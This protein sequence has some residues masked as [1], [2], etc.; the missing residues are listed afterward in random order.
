MLYLKEKYHFLQA[1]EM[2]VI[3]KSE[4]LKIFKGDGI[5][6]FDPDN[7]PLD[8]FK[9]ELKKLLHSGAK[10]RRMRFEKFNREDKEKWILV[11]PHEYYMKT[12]QEFDESENIVFR[13]RRPVIEMVVVYYYN[14]GILKLK[15]GRGNRPVKVS[16]LFARHILG[17]DDE[18]YFTRNSVINFN[19]L[20]D[21]SFCFPIDPHDGIFDVKLVSATYCETS[22]PATTILAKNSNT[23]LLD[24]IR[25]Y[26]PEEIEITA[27]SIRFQFTPSKKKA[28]T[29]ELAVPNFTN[30]AQLQVLPEEDIR[31]LIE[32]NILIKRKE[33]AVSIICPIRCDNWTAMCRLQTHDDHQSGK[34]LGLCNDYE[35]GA[36]ELSP[37]LVEMYDFHIPNLAA[38]LNEINKLEGSQGELYEGWYYLGSCVLDNEKLAVTIITSG[39]SINTDIASNQLSQ[40]G[41]TR[42]LYLDL[43]LTDRNQLLQET[44]HL[45]SSLQDITDNDPFI[46]D[47][48]KIKSLLEAKK[49]KISLQIAGTPACPYRAEINGKTT[50]LD[51]KGYEDLLA[52]KDK[53]GFLVDSTQGVVYS[54]VKPGIFQ[55]ASENEISMLSEYILKKEFIYPGK[56]NVGKFLGDP[57]K[58]FSRIRK[59]VCPKT[60]RTGFK[61]FEMC[62]DPNYLSNKIYK[63]N[64][65]ELSYCLILPADHNF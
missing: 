8:E 4:R 20:K 55:K 53:F 54:K 24:R 12:D 14:K 65:D 7:V 49:E 5:P 33:E 26:E 30:L 1:Y 46:L 2:F 42:F 37:L 6:P 45:Y 47:A 34:L 3:E 60:G 63:F 52:R 61:G 10:G 35:G 32:S 23:G 25:K 59:K 29:A 36:V 22:D 41:C 50:L 17:I 21:K 27:A 48:A 31:K 18:E 58:M 62:N 16:A 40:E 39:F 51:Q 28:K 9:K 57:V 56:T 13:N 15:A 11:I 19:P 64:P 43:S 44:P 38:K